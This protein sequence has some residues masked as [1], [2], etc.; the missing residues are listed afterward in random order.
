MTGSG[1]DFVV[2]DYRKPF[3]ADDEITPFTRAV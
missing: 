1:N 3:L 2:I